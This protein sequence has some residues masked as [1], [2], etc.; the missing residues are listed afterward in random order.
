MN[1]FPY[2]FVMLRYFFRGLWYI[3][4]IFNFPN[5][6]KILPS[7]EWYTFRK[8]I[9]KTRK[10]K[11]LKDLDSRFFVLS[12]FLII[13]HRSLRWKTRRN[14]SHDRILQRLLGMPERNCCSFLLPHKQQSLRPG[15][16]L[17]HRPLLSVGVS[18]ER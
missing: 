16:R 17:H 15:G 1:S 13:F 7:K 18:P 5:L 6:T 14:F 10:T 8:R 12:Y 4:S 11:T 9:L 3:Y 2:I